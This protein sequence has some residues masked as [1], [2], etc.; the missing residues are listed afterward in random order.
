M[1][2]IERLLV[3]HA[4]IIMFIAFAS[5]FMIGFVVTGQ[6]EGSK[7]DWLLAHNE[8]LIN[9]IVLFAVAGVIGKVVTDVSRA[10]LAAYCL[11]GM[12][13]CNALFGFM[14]GMTGA[15]GYEFGGTLANN[16]T[17]A[18][19]MLGVP[20]AAVGFGILLLAAVKK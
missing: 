3:L 18:A 8:A 11:I 15:P 7:A 20:L 14:R 4:C 10:R 12:G 17:A 6:A 19:G 5:G 13:Y 1:N 2:N 16:I 9:S